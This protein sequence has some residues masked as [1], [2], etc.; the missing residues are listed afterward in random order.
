MKKIR[1]LIADDHE[2]VRMGLASLLGTKKDIEVVG[3]AEDGEAAVRKAVKLAPDVVIMDLMMPKKDGVAATV[4]IRRR[5]PSAKIMIL[6]SYGTSDGIA[7]ALS[8]GASGALMKSTEFSE[9]VAAI[10]TIAAGGQVVAPEIRRQ[11]AKDPPVPDLTQR[12]HDILKSIVSGLTT[13]DVAKQFGI[14]EDSVKEHMTAIFAKLGAANRAE[15]IA[16][17]MRKH[18]LKT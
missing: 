17:A 7:H 6:T 3:E 5:L 15:A 1:V 14:R 13:A 4:E 8:A 2:I 16:I 10:H 12:Q 18:L 11:I 9:F